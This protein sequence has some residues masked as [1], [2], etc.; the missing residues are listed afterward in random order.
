MILAWIQQHGHICPVTAMPLAESDL[1][2]DEALRDR[3]L[4]WK[5][6]KNEAAAP[7][8]SSQPAAASSANPADEDD[9]YKF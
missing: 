9:L 3:I 4:A 1:K 6:G 5:M 2:P 7:S 8:G